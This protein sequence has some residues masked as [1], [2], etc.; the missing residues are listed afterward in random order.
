MEI[1]SSSFYCSAEWHFAQ[2]T[3]PGA[4]YAPLIHSLALHIAGKS[5]VFSASIPTLAEYFKANE[6]TIRKALRLLEALGFFE[7]IAQEPGA[8]V[9]YRPIKHRDWEVAHPGRCTTKETMPW[10]P[11]AD[12]L[13]M[14]L[15]AISGQRFKPY[16]N[17]VKGMR[18]T[19]H[20][21]D[22]IKQHFRAFATIE[23]PIGRRWANGFAGK[24]IKYL[25]SQPIPCSNPS[26]PLVGVPLPTVGTSLLPTDGR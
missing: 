8:S 18:K 10:L 19:G 13:G 2:L 26:Q 14:E 4:N 6:K 16:P 7:L 24:F 9:R 25:K 20:S 23:N 5:G 3:G 1:T 12:T 22:Q 15:F 17:F 11:E 21:G